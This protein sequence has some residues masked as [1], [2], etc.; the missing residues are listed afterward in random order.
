[1]V[2]TAGDYCSFLNQEAMVDRGH[3]YNEKMSSDSLFASIIRSGTPE[4]YHYS[5]IAGRE[6]IPISYTSSLAK[7]EYINWRG[8]NPS[9]EKE[10]IS[11]LAEDPAITSNKSD[12]QITISG[13]NN[14]L[15]LDQTS[16]VSTDN[17]TLLIASGVILIASIGTKFFLE[18]YFATSLRDTTLSRLEIDS[19]SATILEA[20]SSSAKIL[21]YY[22]EFQQSPLTLPISDN[23]SICLAHEQKDHLDYFQ[24]L[25]QCSLQQLENIKKKLWALKQKRESSSLEN[26][27][28]GQSLAESVKIERTLI[29][30]KATAEFLIEDLSRTI[31][32]ALEATQQEQAAK[33][34]LDSL[35]QGIN[36][37]VALKKAAYHCYHTAYRAASAANI[38]HWVEPIIPTLE[39]RDDD[40]ISAYNNWKKNWLKWS[41]DIYPQR[42]AEAIQ[43][44]KELERLISESP[45]DNEENSPWTIS[46]D[47]FL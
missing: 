32:R 29:D 36:T 28:L 13:S 11:N 1:M 45:S 9:M 24:N 10:D 42:A 3:F 33:N 47:D 37:S 4:N 23:K 5:L 27:D 15:S 17:H 12:F 7:E 25:Q 40:Y 22:D 6:N 38:L 18:N 2:I 30:R 43:A 44:R 19:S 16:S 14:R 41:D 8:N 31:P 39:K 21:E 35:D 26:D 46:D 34:F 20:D